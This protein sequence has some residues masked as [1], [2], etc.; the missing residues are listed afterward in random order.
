MKMRKQQRRIKQQW[1]RCAQ[2]KKVK[3]AEQKC[4]EASEHV[5]MET[6][7]QGKKEKDQEK[8]S[9]ASGPNTEQVEAMNMK[10]WIC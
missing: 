6:D 7:E 5:E 2:G 3:M 4:D 8:E 9:E 1:M 10:I